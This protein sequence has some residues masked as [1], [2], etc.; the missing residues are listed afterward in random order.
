M[1]KMATE[2]AAMRE[3]QEGLLAK[4][5]DIPDEGVQRILYKEA[6]REL[7]SI[8]KVQSLLDIT[9]V[10]DLASAELVECK[11]S[12]YSLSHVAG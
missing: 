2:V 6:R 11:V 3:L 4:I 1:D 5:V 7:K 9:S 12:Q 10:Q 8:L